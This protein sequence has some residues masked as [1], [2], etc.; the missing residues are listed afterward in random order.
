MLIWNCQEDCIIT[1]LD[2]KRYLE[3]MMGDG[4]G[5]GGTSYM[6]LLLTA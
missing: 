2:R 6:W 4:I 1:F 5:G 3:Q